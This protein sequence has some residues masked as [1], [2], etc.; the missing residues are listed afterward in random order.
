MAMQAHVPYACM[1]K[2]YSSD[3]RDYF[4]NDSCDEQDKSQK[5]RVWHIYHE[6][7]LET[8][9]SGTNIST[10]VLSLQG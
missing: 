5:N 10:N 6:L 2:N 8:D 9:S 3:N 7:C 1:R 4:Q